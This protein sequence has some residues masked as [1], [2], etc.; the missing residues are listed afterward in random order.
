MPASEALL[1]PSPHKYQTHASVY[2]LLSSTWSYPMAIVTRNKAQYLAAVDKLKE[3]DLAAVKKML[4]TQVL[5]EKKIAADLKMKRLAKE[6][7]LEPKTI[8]P[9]EYLSKKGEKEKRAIQLQQKTD[10]QRLTKKAKATVG[11]KKKVKKKPK[12]NSVWTVS[13]GAFESNRNHH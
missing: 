9:E 11:P 3:Q 4:R 8:S 6:H 1:P 2:L 12:K 5:A 7:L 10:V 13:G